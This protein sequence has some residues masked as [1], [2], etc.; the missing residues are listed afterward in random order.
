MKAEDFAAWLSAISGMNEGQRTEAIAA[1]EKASEVGAE[2]G[3]SA[4]KAGKGGRPKD[5]LGTTSHERVAAQGC[6]HCAGREVVGWGP[7]ARTFAVSLQKLWAHLQ[8]ADQ[9]A[10]GASAQ[11]GEMARSRP[12][13]PSS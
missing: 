5:A 9:D 13:A 7:L 8:C 2:G 10:D 1:L 4:K 12:G 6:P 3:G 11:E